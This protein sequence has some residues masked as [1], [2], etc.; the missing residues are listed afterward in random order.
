MVLSKKKYVHIWLRIE[1]CRIKC[2]QLLLCECLYLIKFVGYQH[3]SAIYTRL[4]CYLWLSDIYLALTF[5]WG[6]SC[7]IG[8]FDISFCYW[9]YYIRY[10]WNNSLLSFCWSDWY[11]NLLRVQIGYFVWIFLLLI[12]SGKAFTYIETV[13]W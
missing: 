1:V 4:R 2:I 12:S 13:F 11:F 10:N 7:N 3:I 9:I 6:F 5:I 8:A